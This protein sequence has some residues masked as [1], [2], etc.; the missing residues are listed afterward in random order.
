[1]VFS[2]P[3]RFDP[4]FS[5]ACKINRLEPNP[6]LIPSFRIGTCVHFDPRSMAEWGSEERAA[7]RMHYIRPLGVPESIAA[8]IAADI[9]AGRPPSEAIGRRSRI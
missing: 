1:M 5:R 2:P 6:G 7:K 8:D 4:T 9:R 3:Y